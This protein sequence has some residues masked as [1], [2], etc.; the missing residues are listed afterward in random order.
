MNYKEALDFIHSRQR[1]GTKLGL[2]TTT[3]LLRRV[4]D[5]H[6]ELKFVH[7]AGTNGKGSTSAFISNI[8]MANGYKTGMYISP[9]VNSFTERIQINNR[10][11]SKE[12]L[13]SKY[14]RFKV[15]IA[16]PFLFVN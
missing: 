7:I 10:H 13:L 9:Y 16:L 5:P 1:F 11:I 12:D 15:T 4:G 3:E 2:E 14:F 6:K 8:L